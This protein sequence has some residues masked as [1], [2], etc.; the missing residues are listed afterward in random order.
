MANY[1]DYITNRGV[2]VPDTSA[3]LGDVETEFKGVFGN[4]LD[5][6]P[7]TVQG[8]L[9]EMIARNRIFSIQTAA[10]VSNMLNLQT[11]NGFVLDD[12]GS[13]FLLSR[14]PATHTEVTVDL[15]G[16]SGTLVPAGT[17]L[18]TTDGAIFE[19]V[20]DYRIGTVPY[21][22]FRAVESGPV[23]CVANTLT[24]IL[25]A[26]NGLETATNPANGSIGRDLESDAEFRT[27][28]KA[29]LNVNSIAVLSAI[30]ANLEALP[31]VTGTYLYDNYRDSATTVD[32]ITVPA[33]SVLAIVDGGDPDAIARVLYNKKTIG[34]GY[35]STTTDPNI[36]IVTRNVLDPIY[37]TTYEVKFARPKNVDLVVNITVARQDYTGSDLVTDVK[38]AIVNWSLGGDAEVDG[39]KIGVDVSPFEISAAV[40]NA[41]PEI[42]IRDCKI[43]K[44][45]STP[46]AAIITMD[47]ADKG[48]ISASNITVTVI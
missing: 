17:R 41:I 23:P 30:K 26:V 13:L 39:L 45:G 31:G 46:A 44:S 38:N 35:C 25:D 6:A 22:T 21:P 42:F 1:Y 33:H 34:A 20:S 8:R 29:G 10:A 3:V 11:A 4:D 15:G 43:A 32:E 24:I 7:E 18:Q 48:V 40:S 14:Q 2:I 28:I 16:E 36:T 19:N 47:E 27:R 37:G 12:L 5:V 9:I